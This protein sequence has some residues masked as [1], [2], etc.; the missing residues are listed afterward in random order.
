MGQTYDIYFPVKRIYD[1]PSVTAYDGSSTRGA[2]SRARSFAALPTLDL[3]G[4][5]P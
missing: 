2:A 4:R 1:G 3:S 5:I